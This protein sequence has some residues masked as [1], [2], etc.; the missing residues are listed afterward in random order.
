MVGVLENDGHE[1]KL[2]DAPARNY[3]RTDVL[4]IINDFKP[5]LVVI[6]TSTPSIYNDVDVA[7]KIKIAVPDAL[8]VLVGS[9]PSALSEETLR[10]ST[11]DTICRGEYDYTVRDLA[12]GTDLERVRGISFKDGKKVI[13]NPDRPL[14]KNIDELPFV[15]EVYKKHL[16]IKD[17]FYPSV[18]HPQITIL[19]ARGCPHQCS[20]CPIMF[21]GSYRARSPVNVVEEFEY[22]QKNFKSVKEIMVED[23]TFPISKER[24]MEICDLLIE[25]GVKLKWSCNARVDTDFETLKKM[26]D[27]GLR[28]MCVGF[29]SPRKNVL[30]ASNKK[31]SRDMQVKFM[32][33]TRK[34]GLLTNGCFIIGM[35]NDTA[36]TVRGTIEFAKELN[37]HLAQFYP[38]LVY[39]WTED[40]RWAKENG[41][42]TTE[43]YSKWLTKEGVHAC[44]VSRPGLAAEFLEKMCDVALKGFYMRPSK[45]AEI[46]ASTRS[47][48]DLKRKLMGAKSLVKYFIGRGVAS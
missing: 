29:E 33:N 13:H 16:N 2:I 30:D 1:C 32:E 39:P 35:K 14:I 26:K 3:D 18:L 17:Y 43:D 23:D 24:T 34:L 8:V 46:A 6:D 40:Y 22:I 48:S 37:P 41:Y 31:T 12:R 10:K 20:F 21:K 15:S 19:T 44:V 11:V 45:I 9:H 27:A 5:G 38:L 36:E 7:E 42:L 25:R 28:L 4:K 47:V